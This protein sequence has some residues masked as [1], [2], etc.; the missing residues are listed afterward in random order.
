MS[1]KYNILTTRDL[2]FSACSTVLICKTVP[3]SNF[4]I[5][6]SMVSTRAIVEAFPGTS[7]LICVPTTTAEFNNTGIVL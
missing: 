1:P 3:S 7:I 4:T 5:G 2:K 6:G